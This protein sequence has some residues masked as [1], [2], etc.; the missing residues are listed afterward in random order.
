MIREALNK[1]IELGAV[2]LSTDSTKGSQRITALDVEGPNPKATKALSSHTFYLAAVLGTHER[3]EIAEVWRLLGFCGCT[4]TVRG[5]LAR[6]DELME[7]AGWPTTTLTLEE[8]E[9]LSAPRLL[10]RGK[11]GGSKC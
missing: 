8:L 4:Y 9:G 2:A 10:R 11:G 1:A 5:G 3:I 6:R 7:Q